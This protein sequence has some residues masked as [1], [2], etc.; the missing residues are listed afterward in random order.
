RHKQTSLSGQSAPIILIYTFTKYYLT[1]ARLAHF[2]TSP[3]P[4]RN[5]AHNKHISIF[6]CH[7]NSIKSKYSWFS[8]KDKSATEE[9]VKIYLQS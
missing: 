3:L 5:E 7:I 2:T 9:G 4:D 8:E 6:P 1:H